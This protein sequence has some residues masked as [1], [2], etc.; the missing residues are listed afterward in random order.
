MTPVRRRASHFASVFEK[1]DHATHE[2]ESAS[3]CTK[4]SVLLDFKTDIAIVMD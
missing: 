2:T 3:M 4:L 1:T